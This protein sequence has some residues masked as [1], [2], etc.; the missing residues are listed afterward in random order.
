[1]KQR[2]FSWEAVVLQVIALCAATFTIAALT[3]VSPLSE[4]LSSWGTL[5]V[6]GP[7][8]AVSII[9]LTI[10]G[11]FRSW[12]LLL[13][14]ALCL[15][16]GPFAYFDVARGRPDANDALILVFIPLWKFS[17]RFITIVIAVVTENNRKKHLT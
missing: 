11:K 3:A 4:I 15:S 6:L 14:V 9:A 8:I 2:I 16:L 7:C 5:W 13:L 17:G 1:M 10:P 12:V